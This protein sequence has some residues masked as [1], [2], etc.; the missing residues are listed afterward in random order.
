MFI[1]KV[2]ITIKAG[3]GGDGSISFRREKYVA[4][5]GPDGGDGGRGGSVYVEVDG[6]LST[7]RDIHYKRHYAAGNGAPG[8]G[9]KFY[10][11]DG[12]DIVI[13]VPRGTV[14]YDA[15]SRLVIQ[16]MSLL[17]ENEKFLLAKGGR[18]GWGNKKFA[19]PTRQAPRFAKAGLPGQS[20]E[21]ILELK[22]LAD[23]GLV[24]FPN[25][26][27]S[28]LLSVVSGA[29]PKIANY[30]FTTLTPHLGVVHVREE[31][32]FVLA[33]IPG[34]I[35]GA[36]DGH[37]LGHDFLRHVDRCRL[38]IHVID[39]SGSE[40]RDPLKDYHAIMAEL[41]AFSPELAAR[42]QLIAANKI[43]LIPAA[44]G[45]HPGIP[46][47]FIQAM[48]AMGHQ[49]FPVSAATQ[50]GVRE[51]VSAAMEALGDLPPIAMYESQTAVAGVSLGTPE[52]TEIVKEGED[53]W[54]LSGIWLSHLCANVNFDDYE[55]RMYFNRTLQRFGI[56]EML[57]KQGVQEGDTISVYDI[58]FVYEI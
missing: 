14:I 48:Q 57:E 54:L 26:G 56:Y 36:A 17:P 39:V 6:H 16:D 55:S 8:S 45:V 52:D 44:E 21:V 51:L 47:E 11:K 41:Q 58:E 29:K 1:D 42:P 40:G 15:E 46:N 43:D 53:L 10:G 9:K 37:G 3:R 30:H 50:Q 31:Q 22:M 12:D 33:D 23:A 18:G 34:L 4:A 28:T 19:T 27:K 7:L 20:C 2:K 35:E 32:S 49:V 5:G 38:L 24:G 25:V 13:R